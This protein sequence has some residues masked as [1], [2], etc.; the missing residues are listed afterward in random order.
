MW[1]DATFPLAEAPLRA[2]P[3][4]DYASSPR[5]QRPLGLNVSPDQLDGLSS[6]D[7]SDSSQSVPPH[8]SSLLAGRPENVGFFGQIIS[9]KTLNFGKLTVSEEVKVEDIY[10]SV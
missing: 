8:S 4:R 9:K 2:R 5:G 6:R 1:R 3:S 10:F 7:S